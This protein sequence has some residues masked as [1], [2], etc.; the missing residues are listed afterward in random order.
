VIT[1]ARTVTTRYGRAVDD[2]APVSVRGAPVDPG[3]AAPIFD[4]QRRREV[5]GRLP[6][7]LVIEPSFQLSD[8]LHGRKS[9]I[10]Q[11]HRRYSIDKIANR[12]EM[13]VLKV[14]GIASLNGEI[15]MGG[16][17]YTSVQ[18]SSRRRN[19]QRFLSRPPTGTAMQVD[20]T[21]RLW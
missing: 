15:R 9:V 6:E 12:M 19:R 13:V 2:A 4:L 20:S 8:R 14:A 1:S 16:K 5:S 11:Q 18:A 17:Y 7:E 3:V 10:G 21:R